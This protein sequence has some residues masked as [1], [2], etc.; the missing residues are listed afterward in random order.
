[1]WGWK[2]KNCKYSYS[3]R[4]RN[5]SQ[6]ILLLQKHWPIPRI[7]IHISKSSLEKSQRRSFL[8]IECHCRRIHSLVLC[9][10]ETLICPR[11]GGKAKRE[12]RW[13]IC[14][15]KLLLKSKI[16]CFPPLIILT[17]GA[18]KFSLISLHYSFNHTESVVI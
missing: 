6:P 18:L 16:V 2:K 9:N 14:Y 17:C 12:K 15:K 8:F 1:M 5:G 3:S 7:S 11:G 13:N 10:A 4:N